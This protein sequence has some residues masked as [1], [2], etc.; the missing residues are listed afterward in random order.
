MLYKNRLEDV[1]SYYLSK[2]YS[3]TEIQSMLGSYGTK[4]KAERERNIDAAIFAIKKLIDDDARRREL[5][6]PEQKGEG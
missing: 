6:V 3:Y 2:T 5:N 4:A 1:V